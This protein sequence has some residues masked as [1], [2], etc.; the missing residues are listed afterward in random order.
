MALFK[1]KNKNLPRQANNERPGRTPVN[2][3]YRGD[4]QQ[5]QSPFTKRETK[6]PIKRYIFGLLDIVLLAAV[7]IALLYSLALSNRPKVISSSSAYHDSSVYQTAASQQLASLK[8]RNK[9]TFD[10]KGLAEALQS[11]FP[12]IAAVQTELP[13]FSQRPTIRLTVA[14]PS[15]FLNSPGHS[16]IIS[17][18]GKAVAS[19]ND[20]PRVRDLQ[21]IQD[22]SGYKVISGQQILSTGSVAFINTVIAECARARVPISSLN[23]PRT[24]QELDLHAKDQPYYVKFYL[25]G[26]AL[27][28]TGQFLAARARFKQ[29]TQ[30]PAQYL[31]VRANGKIFYK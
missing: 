24:P 1:Q 20:I 12:E 7:L 29:G 4:S 31:D 8:N 3:Y 9:I 21:N 16:Y 28:Q 13:L 6:K 15:F 23:L 11:R 18:A 2:T 19:A 25:D 27:T 26:D 30:P 22:Q 10:Q 5:S 17:A 14:Q